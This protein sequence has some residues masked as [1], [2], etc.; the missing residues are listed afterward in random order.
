M[1]RGVPGGG[2]GPPKRPYADFGLILVP[3]I[4]SKWPKWPQNGPKMSTSLTTYTELYPCSVC[5]LWVVV[6]VSVGPL[7][8]DWLAPKA[9][10][11]HI[12]A[13]TCKIARVVKLTEDS[14]I[15]M[16]GMVSQGRSLFCRRPK[17]KPRQLW[18]GRDICIYLL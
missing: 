11:P 13:R 7:L 18:S 17:P 14:R 6:G 12:H 9:E 5:N 1:L 8:A 15:M 4:A 16:I 2:K 3:K 10:F